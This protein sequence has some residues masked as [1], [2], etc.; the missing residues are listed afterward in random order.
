MYRCGLVEYVILNMSLVL[1][2]AIEV[3]QFGGLL[4]INPTLLT[5]C[6]GMMES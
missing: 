3:R 6:T 2:Y 1:Y 5:S 4:V